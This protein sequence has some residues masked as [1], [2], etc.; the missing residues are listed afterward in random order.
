M[1]DT[2][3][4]QVGKFPPECHCC[5]SCARFLHSPRLWWLTLDVLLV[6]IAL[7][8]R[9]SLVAR[10]SSLYFVMCDPCSLFSQYLNMVLNRD[11]KH[12]VASSIYNFRDVFAIVRSIVAFESHCPI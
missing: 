8:P 3:L 4:E 7:H 2:A 9:I 11:D 5:H 1:I 6:N 12:V 10:T